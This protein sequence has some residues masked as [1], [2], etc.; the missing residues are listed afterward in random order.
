VRWAPSARA[1][2][3]RVTWLAVAGSQEL[4]VGLVLVVVGFA[5]VLVVVGLVVVPVVV[6]FVVVDWVAVCD[7]C[8]WSTVV[9]L[10]LSYF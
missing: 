2:E 10:P 6:G 7:R 5:V 3:S 4:V 9:Q 1:A 8:G